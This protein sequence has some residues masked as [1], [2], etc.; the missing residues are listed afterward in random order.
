MLEFGGVHTVLSCPTRRALT[1]PEDTPAMLI[2]ARAALLPLR[3]I[4]ANITSEARAFTVVTD[5]VL[6]TVVETPGVVTV[7]ACPALV[8]FARERFKVANSVLAIQATG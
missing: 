1:D 2:A 8:A 6:G 5:T 3:A 4:C 7:V